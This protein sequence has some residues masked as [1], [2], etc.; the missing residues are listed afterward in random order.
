ME[1]LYAI[2]PFD[3]YRLVVYLGS[4]RIKD[5]KFYIE[6]SRFEADTYE[7]FA[8]FLPTIIENSTKSEKTIIETFRGTI[9]T[10]ESH[11]VSVRSL[12]YDEFVE[13]TINK[14][15]NFMVEYPELPM[16]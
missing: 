12:G 16:E 3:K 5:Q 11:T 2:S 4:Y 14:V 10:F 7:T 8:A 1:S 6:K 9:G 13:L 15:K